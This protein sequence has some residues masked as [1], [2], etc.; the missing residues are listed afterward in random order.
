MSPARADAVAVDGAPEAVFVDEA[1][2]HHV[3]TG[4]VARVVVVPQGCLGA[5]EFLRAGRAVRCLPAFRT[6]ASVHRAGVETGSASRA[7]QASPAR[8]GEV[9]GVDAP[10][11]FQPQ[12]AGAVGVQVV[13]DLEA[14][15]AGELLRTRAHQQVVVGVFHDRLGHQRGGAHPLEPRHA[16]GLLLRPVHAAGVQLHHSV[17]VGQAA[18]ADPGLGGVEFG[19]VHPRDQG[20]QHVRALDDHPERPFHRAFR[21]AV[22]EADAA[23]VGDHHRGDGL[24]G[25]HRGRPIQGARSSAVQGARDGAGHTRGGGGLDEVATFHLRES[26]EGFDG[27]AMGASAPAAG[28][29]RKYGQALS[30]QASF[31]T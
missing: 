14:H 30:G 7:A 12:L 9:A 25:V 31:T 11:P 15:H 3:Q 27:P 19:D 4:L 5:C 29:L 17:R 8:I 24:R 28:E 10:L 20:V 18:V 1:L 6:S 23:R 16:S 26:G 13:L 22:G 2:A 21:A